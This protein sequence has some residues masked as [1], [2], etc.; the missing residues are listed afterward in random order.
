M[1]GIG[2]MWARTTRLELLI[3]TIGLLVLLF[4]SKPP[5]SGSAH[6]YDRM[7]QE[8]RP[9][10]DQ[11]DPSMPLPEDDAEHGP[12]D[13]QDEESNRQ[14]TDGTGGVDVRNT[15]PLPDD[16]ALDGDVTVRWVWNGTRFA[17]QKVRIVK[18][19]DGVSS[20]W[21]LD[22]Q[23]KTVLSEVAEGPGTPP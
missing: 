14:Q 13:A 1:V 16:N 19:R 22:P 23:D 10:F 8:S 18:E 15:A 9:Q 3:V 7:P 21:S 5:Q 20:V 11:N 4:C 2:K 6:V 17:P 12:L